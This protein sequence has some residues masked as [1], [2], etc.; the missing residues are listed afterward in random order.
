M[1]GSDAPGRWLDGPVA[2]HGE[3][4][5][6]D[7]AHGVLR[8][9][10]MLAGDILTFGN[11][12]GSRIHVSDVAALIR[13][14]RDGGFVVA[15][16]R[17]FLLLNDE[18]EPKHSVPVFD[19]PTVRMN[20]GSCDPGG[21]L[22]CGSMAYDYRAGA[23]RLYRLDADLSVHVVL[24]HVTIPNGLLWSADG[25]VAFHAD[26][27]EDAVFAYSVN[28]ATGAFGKRE[29]FIDF[30]DVQGSPDGMAMDADGGL[31]IALWGG[32]A[33]RR[34]DD[35]GQLTDVV[36]LPVSNPTSCAI[37]GATGTTLFVT[38]SRQGVELDQEPRAG[39]VFEVEIGVPAAMVHAFAG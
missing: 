31:W 32:A 13:P 14:R 18:L 5:L 8:C 10:D 37:G 38:T 39:T 19:D 21:R 30:R 15:A 23:G 36:S 28:P 4:A 12:G 34:Y 6:W 26:T 16:E 7:S 20:E 22:Y 33:V 29:T 27:A 24:E 2:F 11:G 35:R 17:G 3:G 25:S 1:A 9:V